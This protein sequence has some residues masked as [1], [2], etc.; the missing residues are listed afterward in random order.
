M[1]SLYYGAITVNSPPEVTPAVKRLRSHWSEP[2]YVQEG[3]YGFEETI[4]FAAYEGKL[5]PAEDGMVHMRKTMTT[6]VGKGWA[7]I[8]S[9]EL[10]DELID[11]IRKAVA[12]LHWTGGAELEYIRTLDDHRYL[13]D[14]NLRFP[15]WVHGASLE[16]VNLPAALIAAAFED[17]FGLKLTFQQPTR[18]PTETTGFIKTVMEIPWSPKIQPAILRGPEYLAQDIF[19]GVGGL[20]KRLQHPARQSAMAKLLQKELDQ[21]EL[22]N[23]H[24]LDEI[25][26]DC[27]PSPEE[28]RRILSTPYRHISVPILSETMKTFKS[29][30]ERAVKAG[31][32]GTIDPIVALSVKTHPDPTV[33]QEALRS[34]FMADV[35]SK[36][37]IELSLK[38][39]FRDDQ[40]ILNGP[41]KFWNR[42]AG[43][44]LEPPP[45]K[46]FFAVFA[47]SITEF[48]RIVKGSPTGRVLGVRL[49]FPGTG[50]RFGLDVTD[51]QVL[52]RLFTCVRSLP[53]DVELGFHFHFASSD[54]GLKAWFAMCRVFVSTCRSIMDMLGRDCPKLTVLDLGGGFLPLLSDTRPLFERGLADLTRYIAE[55]LP[56][57]RKLVLEPGKSTSLLAGS[58]ITRVLEIREPVIVQNCIARRDLAKGAP[59]PRAIVV[60]ACLGDARIL[61]QQTQYRNSYFLSSP[62]DTTEWELIKNEGTDVV[63]GRICMEIDILLPAVKLPE[64]L[65]V[66]DY[67][68]FTQAGAYESAAAY[69][70]GEGHYYGND[71]VRMLSADK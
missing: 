9:R 14:W 47:D 19:G 26:A 36:A 58:L 39:G 55:T 41:G 28:T 8:L 27:L 68:A 4:M 38:N 29:S 5:V 66:G 57:V 43:P 45:G 53:A 33:I 15:S 16:T 69:P 67:L 54:N 42:Q 65:K 40:L 1:K 20:P 62:K 46:K 71:T 59:L 22:A 44:V 61:Q 6:P 24:Q 37:E 52:E 56:Q 11:Q 3:R 48:E 21:R 13:I 50:S 35:I 34:G 49:T 64:N 31:S 70:F 23:G 10:P 12:D 2:V 51:A 30:M 63:L 25:G 32:G 7:A 17:L 18:T 60:D